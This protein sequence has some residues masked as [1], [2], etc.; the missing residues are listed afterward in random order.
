MTSTTLAGIYKREGSAPSV[1]QQVLPWWQRVVQ[2]EE[3]GERERE[4][5]KERN[6]TSRHRPS[7]PNSVLITRIVRLDPDQQLKRTRER[8]SQV[9]LYESAIDRSRVQSH[10]DKRRKRI[11]LLDSIGRGVRRFVDEREQFGA[12][13]QRRN[14][15]RKIY[16][17]PESRSSWKRWAWD[18]Y[19][20]PVIGI[21]PLET[22]SS[23]CFSS[24]SYGCA[25]RVDLYR[26]MKFIPTALAVSLVSWQA[27]V[28][29]LKI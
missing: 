26:D 20:R 29:L 12:L 14:A 24:E 9:L 5:E 19:S 8:S 11:I 18:F 25:Q 28:G 23:L 1:N 15:L 21:N 6:S 10:A 2:S 7:F 22:S 4:R 13:E 27:L 3:K 17:G 16:A